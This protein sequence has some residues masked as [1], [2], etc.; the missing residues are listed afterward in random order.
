[1]Y[2]D[3]YGSGEKDQPALVEDELEKTKTLSQVQNLVLNS[4]T[5]TLPFPGISMVTNTV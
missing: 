3:I 5:P 1:M 2:K 4:Q